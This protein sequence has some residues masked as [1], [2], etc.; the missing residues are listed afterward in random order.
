[1]CTQKQYIWNFPRTLESERIK[2]NYI[3]CVVVMWWPRQ[4][5]SASSIIAILIVHKFTT[6]VI[7]E[8]NSI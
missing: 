7:C 8:A 5:G 4:S 3:R 2:S 6:G 1:M